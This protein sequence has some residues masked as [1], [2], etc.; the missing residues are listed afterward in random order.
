[1][2]DEREIKDY[3]GAA[4]G[5]GSMAGMAKIVPQEGVSPDLLDPLRRQNKPRG[6]MCVS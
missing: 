4:G 5:R 2:S 6:V 3:R 1:M